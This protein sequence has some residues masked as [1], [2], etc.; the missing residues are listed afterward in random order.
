MKDEATSE[1][2]PE[3]TEDIAMNLEICDLIK[4]KH[5]APHDAMRSIKRRI[6]HRNPNV[7]LL[8]LKVTTNNTHFYVCLLL[9]NQLVDLCAKNC[10]KHFLLEIA[11][12]EF[13]DTLM[14]MIDTLTVS[15]SVR[16]KALEF[17]QLWGI[18]FQE[19][20]EFGY[21]RETYSRLLS[22]NYN[23]PP[24]PSF[25]QALFDTKTVPFFSSA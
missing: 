22:Q 16:R 24:A 23:F 7:Q 19:N 3:A 11:S 10:G 13:V 9:L 2:L 12:K 17:I 25:T 14:E 8:A 5:V 15:L 18:A 4:G 20:S 21:I 6:Y 1:F